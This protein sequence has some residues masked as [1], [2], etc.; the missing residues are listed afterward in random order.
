MADALK[1]AGVG[2]V[3]KR[4]LTDVVDGQEVLVLHVA[5]T[6]LTGD[7]TASHEHEMQ[8]AK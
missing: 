4:G 5:H 1:V 2:R 6:L 3:M 8:L 7:L